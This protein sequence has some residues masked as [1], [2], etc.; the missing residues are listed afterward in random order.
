MKGSLKAGRHNAVI[1]DA[2]WRV[3]DRNNFKE[4]GR[5]FIHTLRVP[6]ERT[7]API[8]DTPS[9]PRLFLEI[10]SELKR[11]VIPL[12]QRIGK[13]QRTR[14]IALLSFSAD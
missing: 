5:G 11:T 1:A 6:S 14:Q 8:L 13:P 9:R 4:G 10:V 3:S 7:D 2:F 12:L